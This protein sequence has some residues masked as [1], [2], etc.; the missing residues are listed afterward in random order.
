[1][2]EPSAMKNEFHDR[3]VKELDNGASMVL[4]SILDTPLYYQS[5]ASELLP[6]S[7]S[8]L[9]SVTQNF[10]HV[11]GEGGFGCVFKGK[12]KVGHASSDDR[13]LPVDRFIEVAVKT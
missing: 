1:M 8:D 6:F 7:Y 10:T 4:P 2:K 5:A 13:G 9:C 3:A 11:L 12:M